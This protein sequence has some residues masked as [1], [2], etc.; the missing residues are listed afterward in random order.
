MSAAYYVHMQ[1]YVLE[2][3]KGD[4]WRDRLGAFM[5]LRGSKRCATKPTK[6][7]RISADNILTDTSKFREVVRDAYGYM[8][9]LSVNDGI[10]YRES[11]LSRLDERIHVRY[12]RTKHGEEFHFEAKEP[13]ELK[14]H[15]SLPKEKFRSLIGQGLPTSLEPGQL[16]IEGSPLWEK[17]ASEPS[18]AQLKQDRKGIISIIRVDATGMPISRIDHIH[19][20]IEGGFDEWRVT[21]PLPGNLGSITFAL[22]LDAMRK[23]PMVSARRCAPLSVGEVIC[24]RSKASRLKTSNCSI[25]WPNSSVRSRMTTGS[26]SS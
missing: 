17:F 16:T 21:T 2:E 9:S 7:I 13:F 22:D 3:L 4:D 1:R 18:V 26:G 25:T 15:V 5:K 12:V 6:T 19:C 14:M 8:A 24:L 20:K 11:E 23:H 10:A